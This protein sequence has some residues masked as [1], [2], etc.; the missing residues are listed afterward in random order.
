MENGQKSTVRCA[1]DQNFLSRKTVGYGTVWT[2]S[3]DKFGLPSV[4]KSRTEVLDLF[5]SQ[6]FS[7]TSDP[8]KAC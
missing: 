4:V 8:K 2:R 3:A 7:N 5:L 6:L 1:V